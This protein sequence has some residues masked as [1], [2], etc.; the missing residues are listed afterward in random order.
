MRLPN[1]PMKQPSRT[2]T[3]G[4]GGAMTG[5]VGRRTARI[6][7]GFIDMSHIATLDL[8]SYRAALPAPSHRI[9]DWDTSIDAAKSAEINCS[10]N[11]LIALRL[12]KEKP[13]TDYDLADATG[14]QQNS[15]GKRRCDLFKAG[16]VEPETSA[17]GENV[18]RPSPSGTPCIS[19]KITQAGIEYLESV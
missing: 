4:A 2:H 13:M 17:T 5:I 7:K 12:I 8:F 16:F 15:I 11:Q 18:K 6:A 1:M 14:M 9:N 3:T 19:W 10:E